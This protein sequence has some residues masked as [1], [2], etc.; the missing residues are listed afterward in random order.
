[1][2]IQGEQ[3]VASGQKVVV[4]TVPSDRWLI[5]TEVFTDSDG[6][7][8][9]MGS[10]FDLVQEDSTGNDTTK[11]ALRFLRTLLS[12]SAPERLSTAVGLKFAPGTSVVL[13]NAPGASG[14][15]LGWNLI[16]YLARP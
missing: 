9:R 5:M 4:Y 16:G 12:A 11:L 6:N 13:K 2:N 15:T 3:F 10:A 1:M 14:Q 7:E 8:S